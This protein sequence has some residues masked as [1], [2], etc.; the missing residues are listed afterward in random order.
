MASNKAKAGDT[1]LGLPYEILLKI[2]RARELDHDDWKS[3]RLTCRQLAYGPTIS[4]L[5]HTV[6][7][8]RLRRDVD[9]FIGIA[10]ESRLA[11]QVRVI[12]WHELLSNV[13]ICVPVINSSIKDGPTEPND[14]MPSFNQ[15]ICR[16]IAHQV[17]SLDWVPTPHERDDDFEAPSRPEILPLA[18]IF[19]AAD[20]M[21]GVHTLVS[22]PMEIDHPLTSTRATQCYPL[23][24]Q[25]LLGDYLCLDRSASGRT[26]RGLFDFLLPLAASRPPDRYITRLYISDENVNTG[27]FSVHIDSALLQTA[28]RNLTHL[29]VC[30]SHWGDP[31]E[32]LQLGQCV[33]TAANLQSLHICA[34]KH[35][36]D[37]SAVDAI[38]A[39]RVRGA[40]GT[41][42]PPT[43]EDTEFIWQNLCELQIT[44][45]IFG[46]DTVHTL[47]NF[48]RRQAHSLRALCLNECQITVKLLLTLLTGNVSSATLNLDRF[49]ILTS[50]AGDTDPGFEN[51]L[52]E[53][54]FPDSEDSDS[55]DHF[56]DPLLLPHKVGEK[57]LVDFMNGS[58]APEPSKSSSNLAAELKNVRGDSLIYTHVAIFDSSAFHSGSVSDTRAR[59]DI[60]CTMYDLEETKALD[61]EN[62]D[63]RDLEGY[64]Y[65]E[66]TDFNPSERILDGDLIDSSDGEEVAGSSNSG[67]R[68]PESIDGNPEDGLR[69]VVARDPNRDVYFW[70]EPYNADI[71]LPDSTSPYGEYTSRRY[72]TEVW[73]FT[74]HTGETALGRDA[75]EFWDSWDGEDAGDVAEALPVGYTMRAF[76]NQTAKPSMIGPRFECSREY[77]KAK[78]GI[79]YNL[80]KSGKIPWLAYDAAREDKIISQYV[81]RYN[82][83]ESGLEGWEW[84]HPEH[85]W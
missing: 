13:P 83:E 49:I 69:W 23:T 29:D 43:P 5:F 73:R 53:V 36:F 74:H 52:S 10:S 71:H 65:M 60:V 27:S 54:T 48:M 30:I 76:I 6:G 50:E 68:H 55:P 45:C 2:L 18:Q 41:T 38:L 22:K 44:S 37:V 59:C 78:G 47:R 66:G 7:I 33:R 32:L 42:L 46:I 75:L 4:C 15:D 61:M 17:L 80:K 77:I 67:H 9:A 19:K 79:K 57:Q 14:W 51:L 26:N 24:A 62:G 31:H 34:E 82:W 84:S 85:E 25:A 72:R 35:R 20:S 28:F 39:G 63:V 81:N 64:S 11:A 1:L 8:S 16:N 70:Q 40:T 12:T 21:P 3:L 56:P 58:F